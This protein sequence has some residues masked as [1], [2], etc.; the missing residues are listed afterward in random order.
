MLS[1]DT[2]EYSGLALMDVSP[3]ES[4]ASMPLDQHSL[5]LIR[6]Q[7]AKCLEMIKD[8]FPVC[9]LTEKPFL[10]SWECRNKLAILADNS[11]HNCATG[12]IPASNFLPSS[13]PSSSLPF[14][15]P[16][17]FLH[18]SFSP[19]PYFAFFPLQCS[20]QIVSKYPDFLLNTVP[21]SAIRA[22]LTFCLWK[23][24]FCCNVGYNL[25]MKWVLLFL[26]YCM[27]LK[28]CSGR[29]VF[30]REVAF[31]CPASPSCMHVGQKKK[32]Q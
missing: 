2:S 32:K 5:F 12:W 26:T 24:I 19:F 7:Y 1:P 10:G 11:V 9:Q 25:W 28:A 21:K 8:C 30:R 20:F 17:L 27:M 4:F 6:I 29:L 13:I 14:F 22:C 3:P 18:S 31:P 16:S 23:T 15:S